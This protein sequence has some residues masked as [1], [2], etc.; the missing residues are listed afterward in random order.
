M[1]KILASAL[2]LPF[3]LTSCG[4][5]VET[6]KTEDAKMP[7]YIETQLAK[8]FPKNYT[9]EKTGRLVGSSTI[10]LASQGIGRVQAI[11]VHEGSVIKKGQLLVSLSDTV[12]NYDLKASQAANGLASTRNAADSTRLALDKTVADALIA[13]N[14]AKADYETAKQDG[15]KRLEKAQRDATKSDIN[16]ST[17]DAT[18]TIAQ[19]EA[20]LSKAQLD[21]ENLKKSNVQT[22]LNYNTSYQL[23][24]SDLKKFLTRMTYEG[25]KLF[26]VTAQY[27]TDN[28]LARKYL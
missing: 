28:A 2:L 23:S 5:P 20:N 4:T 11:N 6:A 16:S 24:V 7:F 15:A 19:L 14:K 26:G 22:L 27:P 8:E 12:A 13:L 3:V 17:S 21:Y 9:I 18:T 10:S 1:K 25:D